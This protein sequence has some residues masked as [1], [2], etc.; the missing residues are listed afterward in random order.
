[1]LVGRSVRRS[2][3]WSVRPSVVTLL[4]MFLNILNVDGHIK[5]KIKKYLKEFLIFSKIKFFLVC[6][7]RNSLGT[8]LL[9]I[10]LVGCRVH[11]PC[12][13]QSG[14]SEVGYSKTR[15]ITFEDFLWDS[16][17]FDM[18]YVQKKP[19]KDRHHKVCD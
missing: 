15:Q 18:G 2:V 9:A 11:P 16:G 12:G 1:M 4:F 17:T 13:G 10:G 8:Q 14:S 5:V 6:R 19:P 3:G 7:V